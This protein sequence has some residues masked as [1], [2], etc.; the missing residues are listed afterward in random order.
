MYDTMPE[1]CIRQDVE[2]Q[3]DKYSKKIKIFEI[4]F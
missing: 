1:V 4:S 2:A 3:V